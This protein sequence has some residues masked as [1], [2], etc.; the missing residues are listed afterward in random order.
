M[1]GRYKRGR[2]ACLL[3]H[4]KDLFHP[5]GT[6]MVFPCSDMD[7]WC[8]WNCDVHKGLAV[9]LWHLS[10]LVHQ[11]PEFHQ[12]STIDA[13]LRGSGITYYLIAETMRS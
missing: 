10:I 12:W 5:C 2:D 11:K 3:K 9:A 13:F 6:T 4:R 8:P 7:T 1:R